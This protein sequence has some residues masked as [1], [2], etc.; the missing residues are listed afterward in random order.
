MLI[1]VGFEI[2]VECEQETPMLLALYPHPSRVLDVIGQDGLSLA[3]P[4]HIVEFKDVF[5]NRCGRVVVP[6]GRT[7]L[8]SDFLVRDD[9][10]PDPV[11]G[12]APQQGVSDL[13]NEV[14]PFLTA[15]RYV[16]S[17]ALTETAWRLFGSTPPGWTR[18]QAICD[19]VHRH[20]SFGYQ[21]GRPTKTALD[22]YRERTGVCRDFAHLAVALCR[23]MNIPARY[24][25]GWLGDIGVPAQ[26]DPGDFCAWFE[27]YLG[28]R[29]HTFD[30]RYNTPRIG[31]ILMVRGR[32]AA[33]VAM[34]TTFGA[35]RLTAFEVWCDEVPAERAQ[36]AISEVFRG[37]ERL[38]RRA[39]GIGQ[40]EA[41]QPH[42]GESGERELERVGS[43]S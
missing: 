21:H 36:R 37:P 28:G 41:A 14:I 9:G 35:N 40:V 4:L 3:P 22:A 12:D 7:T 43:R 16:E 33:D 42:D 34:M 24:A 2:T 32:D 26:G 11:N 10:R 20:I 30:A 39:Q 31:R 8:H 19:F 1:R 5:G 6:R 27:A 25:S 13:P 23:A 38:D 18:V 17:D 29:W 15:S